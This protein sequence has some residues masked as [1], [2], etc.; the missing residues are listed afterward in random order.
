MQQRGSWHQAPAAAD[1]R[2]LSGLPQ[3]LRLRQGG[4]RGTEHQ[5]WRAHQRHL[6]L[7]QGPARQLQGPQA[8]WPGGG[9]RHGR[10]HLPPRG[11]RDLQGPP[12]CGTGA[13]FRRPGQ[14]AADPGRESRHPPGDGAW[15][16]SRRRA[17]HPGQPGGGR[18]LAGADPLGRPRPVPAGRRRARRR[19]A[20]HGRRPICQ[21]QRTAGDPPRRRDRQARRDARR[22]GGSKGAH[23]RQLR[24]HP[25]R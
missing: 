1:R 12:G 16:R 19:R 10:A 4:R 18:R 8:Q 15:L 25:R 11:R 6:R 3:L 7:P 22:G 2:P 23:R 13:L 20:L 21:K 24:Q 14:P 5:G 17:R 9:F